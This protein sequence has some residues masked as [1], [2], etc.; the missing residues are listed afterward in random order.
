[1]KRVRL[2]DDDEPDAYGNTEDPPEECWEC[3]GRGEGWGETCLTC[4][5]F[6]WLRRHRREPAPP[7]H[8]TSGSAPV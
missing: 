6:G 5:G 7:P 2:P 1:M 8:L 3:D 4:G